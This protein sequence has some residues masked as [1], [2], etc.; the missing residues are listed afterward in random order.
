MTPPSTVAVRSVSRDAEVD[1][2]E[3]SPASRL[4]L[5]W[6]FGYWDVDLRVNRS[7]LCP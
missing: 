1:W 5:R 2:S 7:R 4:L 3:G 6:R